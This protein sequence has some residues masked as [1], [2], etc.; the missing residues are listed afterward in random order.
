MCSVSS[1]FCALLPS[2][3]S[4][5]LTNNVDVQYSLLVGT[6]VIFPLRISTPGAL[7]TKAQRLEI[8]YFHKRA[9]KGHNKGFLWKISTYLEH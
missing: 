3:Y 2:C 6:A 9:E 4:E 5:L 8:N 1:S 7:L